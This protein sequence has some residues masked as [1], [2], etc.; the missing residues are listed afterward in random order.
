[1]NLI[2]N[3]TRFWNRVIKTAIF[4]AISGKIIKFRI[5]L[6][7]YSVKIF[8]KVF[9]VKTEQNFE[10]KKDNEKKQVNKQ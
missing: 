3:I 6:R 7:K 10:S 2:L 9:D 4:S 8:I 1:M 5:Y